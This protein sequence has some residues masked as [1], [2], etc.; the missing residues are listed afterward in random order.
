MTGTTQGKNM[1]REHYA[2]TRRGEW[3]RRS[4]RGQ[5]IILVAFV[6]IALAL[7]T[8]LVVDGGTVLARYAQLRRAVDA[9]AVQA[10]NQFREF[11]PLY[12]ASGGDMYHA[13]TQV[14]E[15]QGFD[16][17]SIR[18]YA[19]TGGGP[20]VQ[21]GPATAPIPPEASG[22]LC[23]TPLRKL[24]RVD[25]QVD[26]G[27]PFLSL[28]GW[29]NITVKATSVAEAAG[30]DL[31]LVLDRSSS[32]SNDSA[33]HG[34]STDPTVCGGPARNCYP[35]E[36][37]RTNAKLLV[38]K[39]YF[40]YDRVAIIEFDR[41]ARV[42][43]PTANEFQEFGSIN[44]L[45]PTLLVSDKQKALNA[46]DNPTNDSLL[47]IIDQCVTYHGCT[48]NNMPGLVDVQANTNTGSALRA[49]TTVLAVQGRLRSAVWMMLLL[50]DGAPN[51]T[52]PEGSFLNGYCPPS[53]WSYGGVYTVDG[54]GSRPAEAPYAYPYCRR[55][56][57]AAGSGTTPDSDLPYAQ[58]S[59]VCKEDDTTK[60][61]PGTTISRLTDPLYYKDKYDAVD[62]A[63]DQADLMAT[64]SIVAFVIGLGSGVSGSSLNQSTR[65]YIE[66]PGSPSNYSREPYAGERLLRYIAD[67]GTQ[68]NLW[69]CRSNY[70]ESGVSEFPNTEPY[71]H[72]GNYWFA[73]SGSS[74]QSIFEAIASRIFT[75]IAQ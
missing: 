42:Y 11:R 25:G 32:M 13:A 2:R 6:F 4:N 54:Y 3:V 5:V 64:N 24:V 58:I 68:P 18:A 53:T 16:S 38:D 43:N 8:G 10:S 63:R 41:V 59:R 44:V 15:A 49:A 52:D 47:F 61:A 30:I 75:R 71:H 1:R 34:G 7:F 33:S 40:P 51:V 27:L 39:L 56:N 72:C 29:R 35:F 17:S 69:R 20:S 74:L 55:L 21:A 12:S 70:W 66:A 62:Y 23:T 37:V 36:D 50:S 67:V 73:E 9:A 31:T 22:Q 65:L 14:V 57:V 45:T 60:C 48:D 46:L 19:C 26:V 28:I